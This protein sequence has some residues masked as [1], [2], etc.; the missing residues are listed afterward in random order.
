M[1]RS[2]TALL[3]AL[4]ALIVVAIGVGIA[5][6][7][8]SVLWASQFGL[9]IDFLVFWR[10]AVNVWL[11]GNGVDLAVQLDPAVVAGLGLPGAEVP[12]SVTIGLL[13]F[14]LLAALLGRHTGRRAAESPH[15][16]VGVTTAIVVYGLL[17]AAL[18]LTAGTDALQPSVP[19]GILFPTAV[20][21]AGV[22]IGARRRGDAHAHAGDERF[23]HDGRDRG[24]LRRLVQPS[25]PRLQSLPRLPTVQALPA[26]VHSIAAAALRAGTAAAAGTI[27][28][29]AIAVCTLILVNYATIIGLY[30]AVQAG[31]LGGISLTLAQLALVPNLV[32]WAA[33]WF[34]GPGIAVGVG[35]SVSP[36][37]TAL[38][39]VPGLPI[40][41]ILPHGSLAFGFLGL[42]VPVLSGFVT[43]LATRNR[44]H[45][46]GDPEPTRG[47]L[48]LT[49]A[50][51]GIVAGVILGLLA[52]WSGG[53]LG[54]GRLVEVGPNAVLV[55]ALAA[56]EVGVAAVLGMLTPP[57]ANRRITR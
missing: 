15:R 42:L 28:V 6:V 20:F 45:R 27:A 29:S 47:Q 2:T 7:P 40:L 16:R 21:A 43:A 51:A 55:G 54:P 1:N 3:A 10:A 50:A 32:I 23:G 17:A 12:F 52:W 14:A 44:E 37:G 26:S 39:P 34:V 24:R 18:A 33:A 41:G 35:T 4:E 13:G 25:L 53:A 22:L 48:A 5:L 46:A 11:L 31:V 19:Q 57:L 38:G 9:T 49:G 56:V 8:L 30:E 36:A